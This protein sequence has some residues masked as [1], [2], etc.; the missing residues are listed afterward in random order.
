M[1]RIS[2]VIP[3]LNEEK[4][5]PILLESLKNQTFKDYEVIVADA[6]SKDNTLEIANSYGARVV[7]GG[8]PGP[9]RNRGAEV[10]TGEF[11]FFFDSD[12]LLPNDFL[13]KAMTEMDDRFIDLATC[14]FLPLSELTI[15]KAVFQLSNL[16]VKM[17]QNLNP[18]AAGFCIF[19]NRRLFKR[20]G[21][22]DESVVI[23]ED[24]DLVERASKFRPLRFLKTTSLSVSVRRLDKEGRLSL[25][26][27]YVKVEMHLLTKGSV[28]DDIIEYEFGNFDE[29]E[30]SKR[31]K[32]LNDIEDGILKL[33]RQ[34]TKTSSEWNEK[35]AEV[36]EKLKSSFDGL[37]E[38][39][40]NFFK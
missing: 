17:N 2:V 3:A 20:V 40:R 33:D 34:F 1:P 30:K 27:K 4:F 19:I 32:L 14:E 21:G 35:T 16:I 12:V 23:A 8:M 38:S 25:L 18:R 31:K 13:E 22:F 15:D 28:K 5:L 37:N 26:Q 9:G 29:A 24:H 10:A 7:P 39:I 36:E 11:L 6:G